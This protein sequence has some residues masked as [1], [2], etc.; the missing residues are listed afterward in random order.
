MIRSH[1]SK[2]VREATAREGASGGDLGRCPFGMCI[3]LVLICSTSHSVLQISA[4][5]GDPCFWQRSWKGIL[6]ASPKALP[7]IL[8]LSLPDNREI[9]SRRAGGMGDGPG[10]CS[11]QGWN[12]AASRPKGKRTPTGPA[13]AESVTGSGGYPEPVNPWC[14]PGWRVSAQ[15]RPAVPDSGEPCGKSGWRRP[16]RKGRAPLRGPEGLPGGERG[17]AL[18]KNPASVTGRG[19]KGASPGAESPPSERR[20]RAARAGR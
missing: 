5:K 19:I 9:S 2:S 1:M 7:V 13:T 18:K 14:Q 8:G 16:S 17:R 12:G 11:G 20:K 10:P 4:M 3:P 6:K 15:V